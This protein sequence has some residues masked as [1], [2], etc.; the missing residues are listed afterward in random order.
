MTIALPCPV[1]R[2]RQISSDPSVKESTAT[3]ISQVVAVGSCFFARM[4]DSRQSGSSSSS[5]LAGTRMLTCERHCELYELLCRKLHLLSCVFSWQPKCE[6]CSTS[7]ESGNNRAPTTWSAGQLRLLFH[8]LCS[9]YQSTFLCLI[10]ALPP[11]QVR[12]QPPS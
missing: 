1:S 5:S 3:T 7:D 10:S 11:G 8:P 2:F 9:S 6:R 12:E 4:R